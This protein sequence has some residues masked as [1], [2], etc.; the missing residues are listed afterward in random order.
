MAEFDEGELEYFLEDENEDVT[1]NVDD[2]LDD[3]NLKHSNSIL[4]ISSDETPITPSMVQNAI[5]K[6]HMSYEHMS[7]I[8]KLAPLLLKK[9]GFDIN[10]PF[11]YGSETL[12]TWACRRGYPRLVSILLEHPEIDVNFAHLGVCTA[13]YAA[14]LLDNR[15]CISLLLKDKRVDIVKNSEYKVAIANYN[16]EIFQEFILHR[17]DEIDIKL[18]NASDATSWKVSNL[19]KRFIKNPERTRFSVMVERGWE[20][21]HASLLFSNVVFLCDNHLV[22]DDKKKVSV[23]YDYT[24][25]K[26]ILASPQRFYRIAMRLPMDIQM[27]LC[28]IVYKTGKDTISVKMTNLALKHVVKRISKKKNKK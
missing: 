4:S 5:D 22:V 1:G 8:C 13:L 15:V 19:L 16:Q 14:C 20:D 11:V 9:R 18:L 27:L 6:E 26:N 17:G 10:N 21:S 3:L 7:Y 24:E 28:N 2:D 23:R 25:K 12:L